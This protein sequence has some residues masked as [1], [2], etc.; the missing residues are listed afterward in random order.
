MEGLG[1]R[2][3]ERHRRVLSS[4]VILGASLAVVG[5]VLI[6]LPS[7]HAPPPPTAARVLELVFGLGYLGLAAYVGRRRPGQPMGPLL[8]LVAVLWFARTLPYSNDPRLFTLG[9]VVGAGPM[10][11]YLHVAAAMPDGRL[12][13]LAR[14][15]TVAAGYVAVFGFQL[16]GWMVVDNCV[17][18]IE[19]PGCPG[20][21]LV[22]RHDPALG[23]MVDDAHAWALGGLLLVVTALVADRLRH[24]PRADR[25]A[26]LAVLLAV[27]LR[28]YSLVTALLALPR[29]DGP[30]ADAFWW[31]ALEAVLFDAALGIAVVVWMV[32]YERQAASG[33]VVAA[34]DVERRRI[35]RD[36][37]DGAQ[38]QLLGIA[39][40]LDRVAQGLGA[41][42]G[43]ARARVQQAATRIHR[44][45]DDLRALTRGIEPAL[46]YGGIAVALETLAEGAPLPVEL[47]P[48]PSDRLPAEV[49]RA[50][51]FL[52]REA[53]VN[54]A[55][56]AGA[57]HVAVE[58]RV[59]G[60]DLTVTV[61]DDG[62]GGATPGTGTGLRGLQERFAALAGDL[63]VHSV[64]GQGTV[65][66]GRL[67]VSRPAPA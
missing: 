48:V 9:L 32:Q 25:P 31:R 4:L 19:V 28:G 63:T 46:D 54:A 42:D 58:V 16:A 2:S 5:Q 41:S 52:V 10:P 29:A 35:E 30:W 13:T 49:E 26:I 59:S 47:G 27:V 17:E 51:C 18:P 8:A 7:P 36:L 14:R 22:V 62:V 60:T 6:T 65:L 56:H 23:G 53:V 20:N 24:E 67:P 38:Q 55:R 21:L 12:H 3:L 1:G 64:P 43:A 57:T 11:V 39:V 34:G 45:V 15:V 66:V 40:E 44:T 50:V 37:H 61:R 33:R